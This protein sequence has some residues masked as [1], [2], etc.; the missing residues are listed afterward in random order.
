MHGR[1]RRAATGGGIVARA[2]TG[3]GV[4]LFTATMRAIAKQ[5]MV[6][7]GFAPRGSPRP[8]S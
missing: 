6:V 5:D 7:V 1:S 8:G 4:R 3:G 2:A